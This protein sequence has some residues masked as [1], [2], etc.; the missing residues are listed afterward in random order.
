M[1]LQFFQRMSLSGGSVKAP[2]SITCPASPTGIWVNGATSSATRLR[3]VRPSQPNNSAPIGG[4]AV[5][6]S[7]ATASTT[8]DLS[9]GATCQPSMVTRDDDSRLSSE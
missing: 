5:G 4:S 8:A 1:K 3:A 7:G 6:Q 9:R 2:H